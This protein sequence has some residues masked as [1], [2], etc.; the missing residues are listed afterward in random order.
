MRNGADSLGWH[1]TGL[2]RRWFL[3]HRHKTQILYYYKALFTKGQFLHF[4]ATCKRL[5]D[6]T[7]I[8]CASDFLPVCSVPSLGKPHAFH[9]Q[10]VGFG[11]VGVFFTV[12]HSYFTMIAIELYKLIRQTVTFVKVFY[13]HVPHPFAVGKLRCCGSLSCL[14]PPI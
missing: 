6:S 12:I 3:S 7:C 1:R 14:Q 4:I 5:P 2:C 10:E 13:S 9:F 8:C 11:V